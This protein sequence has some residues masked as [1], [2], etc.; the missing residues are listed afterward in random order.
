MPYGDK[1]PPSCLG[2]IG[3]AEESAIPGVAFGVWADDQMISACHGVT[4]VEDPLPVDQ[5][6]MFVLGSVTKFCT[7]AALMCLVSQGRVELEA[8]LRGRSDAYR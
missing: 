3:S 8:S 6:M 7:A 4:S 5:D 1:Y 2:L